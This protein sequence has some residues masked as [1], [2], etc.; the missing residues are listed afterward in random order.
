MSAHPSASTVLEKV[1]RKLCGAV[2]LKVSNSHKVQKSIPSFL[3]SLLR[4]CVYVT[5]Q[6]SL[7][8]RL[9]LAAERITRYRSRRR[10]NAASKYN[11][12][13]L[14]VLAMGLGNL[15]CG[16]CNVKRK[17]HFGIRIYFHGWKETGCWKFYDE[18]IN[19]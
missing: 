18:D 8:T 4:L 6:V 12:N 16:I 19:R 7:E 3:S 15:G 13:C 11:I 1:C 2:W 14:L 10:H 5:F 17:C 9:H